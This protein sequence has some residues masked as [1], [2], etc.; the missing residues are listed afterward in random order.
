MTYPFGK[1]YEA[2]PLPRNWQQ[3]TMMTVLEMTRALIAGQMTMV[4]HLLQ[5]SGLP[6]EERAL[7]TSLG[8]RIFDKGLDPML[9]LNQWARDQAADQLQDQ[10]VHFRT[11]W[12]R[13]LSPIYADLANSLG[14]QAG[15]PETVAFRPIQAGYLCG[16]VFPVALP[17]AAS[18]NMMEA[19][20]QADE[21]DVVME[22]HLA[23]G[24]PQLFGSFPGHLQ[25]A[26]SSPLQA[27]YGTLIAPSHY[28]VLRTMAREVNG[29]QVHIL[30]T[31][32]LQ[33]L[34]PEKSFE[35][36]QDDSGDKA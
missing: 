12:N 8:E 11:L 25:R 4:A 35:K 16:D 10:V 24:Y 30:L 13:F 34:E 28:R 23:A 17:L 20:E 21:E 31:R 14:Y 36:I 1:P 3:P 9:R 29:K 19:I 22:I 6:P 32:P 2:F 7:L 5:G 26:Q 33:T 27:G 18:W 15:P